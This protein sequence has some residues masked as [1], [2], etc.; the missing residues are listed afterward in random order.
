MQYITRNTCVPLG[1]YSL[2]DVNGDVNKSI[3]GIWGKHCREESYGEVRQS[4]ADIINISFW[5]NVSSIDADRKLQQ[6]LSA[7][8][9]S[10]NMN[11]VTAV[12]LPLV[13][14]GS[15]ANSK[16]DFGG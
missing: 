6:D 5:G 14:E 2:E 7:G 8:T 11:S 1:P 16:I 3:I 15:N 10:R 12:A 4:Q 13:G 9:V